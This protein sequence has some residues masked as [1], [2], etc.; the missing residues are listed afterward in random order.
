MAV[1]ETHTFRLTDG[2]DIG[3]F[4]DADRRVQTELMLRKPTFLRRTTAHDGHGDWI[5]V[6]VWSSGTDADTARAHFEEQPANL[7][8]NALVDRPTFTTRRYETLD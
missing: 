2:A 3:S 1:I 4:L 8:F 5:V 7:A 6:V